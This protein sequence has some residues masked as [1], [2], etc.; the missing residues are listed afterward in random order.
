MVPFLVKENA[1]GT[2]CPSFVVAN[3]HLPGME[4]FLSFDITR[5]I[6]TKGRGW[7]HAFLWG[8]YFSREFFSNFFREFFQ[9]FSPTAF[10]LFFFALASAGSAFQALGAAERVGDE[11][12][13][14]A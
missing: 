6:S 3:L 1:T 9:F 11:A 14:P 10:V 7:F 12:P 8:G 4:R 2:I 5:S 13:K